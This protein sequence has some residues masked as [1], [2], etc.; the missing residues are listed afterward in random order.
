MYRG[1]ARITP[2]EGRIILAECELWVETCRH[3]LSKF[4]ARAEAPWRS[5][6]QAGRI[7]GAQDESWSKIMDATFGA[8]DD[9]QWEAVMTD[10]VGLSEMSREDV[11]RVVRTR[12]DCDR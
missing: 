5:L 9:Q 2:K 6:L 4:A 10:V 1:R 7:V 11:S 12:V 8:V 3:A